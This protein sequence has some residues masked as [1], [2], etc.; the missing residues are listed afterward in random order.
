MTM[1][2]E[3]ERQRWRSAPALL[4][5]PPRRS[6]GQE[7]PP[8]SEGQARL[9]QCG[10]CWWQRLRLSSA[11]ASMLPAFPQSSRCH[12]LTGWRP[13]SEKSH[14]RGVRTQ[15]PLCAQ[16]SPHSLSLIR[17]QPCPLPTVQG[18][19]LRLRVGD[20]PA[21]G[22]QRVDGARTCLSQQ[23]PGHRPEHRAICQAAR[24]TL[25][26][27]ERRPGRGTLRT[28]SSGHPFHLVE[29]SVAPWGLVRHAAPTHTPGGAGQGPPCDSAACSKETATVSPSAP[30]GGRSGGKE[31]GD[32][33]YALRGDSPLLAGQCSGEERP[34][35]RTIR[36]PLMGI[37]VPTAAGLWEQVRECAG[38]RRG[39]RVTHSSSLEGLSSPGA[40]QPLAPDRDQRTRP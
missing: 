16:S 34:H 27:G 18:G 5:S 9:G 39:R 15:G 38:A 33:A 10:D 36:H 29:L 21:Q 13:P 4:L 14:P 24:R 25:G 1:T 3:G 2:M 37:R 17:T 35:W 7:P 19:K 12:L 28:L 22:H 30:S 26:C 32:L 8:F 20:R 23:R 40:A 6:Q 31:R 11:P